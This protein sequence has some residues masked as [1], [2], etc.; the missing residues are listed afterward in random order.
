MRLLLEVSF[1][2]KNWLD[3]TIKKRKVGNTTTINPKSESMGL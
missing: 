3:L 1:A 2:F